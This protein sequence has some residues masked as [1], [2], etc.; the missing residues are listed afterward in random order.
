MA[1][2]ERAMQLMQQGYSEQ[3]V[4][5]VLREERFSPREIEEALSQSQIKSTLVESPENENFQEPQVPQPY[6]KTRE[7]TAPE[8]M[9]PSITE[10]Q[11]Y[12]EY[13]EQTEY[14]QQVYPPEQQVYPQEYPEYAPQ[15]ADIET[16]NDIAEQIVEEKTAKLKKQVSTFTKFKE[17]SLIEIESMDERIAKLE[18]NFNE[19]QMAVI[20][21]IGEYGD[22]IK[23]IAKEMHATQNSFS[24]MINPVLDKKR[25][26]K[27]DEGTEE[28]S[29]ESQ[30]AEEKSPR[31]K[32]KSGTDFESYL[33]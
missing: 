8:G 24:K 16:M 30:T 12:Q 19:L 5:Q 15:A 17:E 29:N 22:D 23:N 28:D 32:K 2:L 4:I 27:I 6:N 14:P 33:R 20:R 25:K 3:Q 11:N 31:G 7:I 21:K 13:P 10:N 1:V 26:T 9:Q 18:N